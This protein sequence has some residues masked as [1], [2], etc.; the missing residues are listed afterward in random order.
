MKIEN[1]IK[2][3]PMA[4]LSALWSNLNIQFFPFVEEAIPDLEDW[5]KEFM[6][7]CAVIIGDDDF[8]QY[9]WCGNGRPPHSRLSIFKAF[10]LKHYL[11]LGTTKELSRLLRSSTSV[12]RICGWN[13]PSEVPDDATFCRAF[14]QFSNDHIAEAIHRQRGKEY[15]GDK[16]IFNVSH[17][18]SK[19]EAREKGLSKADKDRKRKTAKEA[20]ANI[21]PKSDS[22]SR[23]DRQR[24]RTAQVNFAELPKDCDWGCKMNSKGK[25]EQWKGYKLHLSVAQGD[26]PLLAF[27][28][29][30]SLHD[31]QAIVPMM[32]QT[33]QTYTYLYDLADAGYDAQ[34]IRLAS[35]ELGHRPIIDENPRRGAPKV[36]DT[37]IAFVHMSTPE[38]TRYRNR[39]AVERVFGHLHDAHGGRTVRV[40]GHEKVMLHLMFGILVI[41]AEQL[42]ALVK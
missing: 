1:E 11:N 31:S 14:K 35:E 27:V 39:T 9:Q 8:R 13:F 30:A 18:S 4:K 6:A 37:G 20:K 7:C 36:E 26:I 16:V 21:P 34:G 19:I 5:Q 41:F 15:L 25:C 40:R 24:P 3:D 33:S 38:Q 42:L 10:I 12:C 29:S 32:Q 22:K 23:I 28:S 2:A 17:D